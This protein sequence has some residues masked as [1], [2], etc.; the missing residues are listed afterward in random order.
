MHGGEKVGW[1][2]SQYKCQ[3]VSRC[4]YLCFKLFI[5]SSCGFAN[6]AAVC[7]QSW[8]QLLASSHP[9]QM[10]LTHFCSHFLLYI[11]VSHTDAVHPY[12]GESSEINTIGA[13]QGER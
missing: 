2:R 12:S 8:W 13:T 4:S 10:L 5:L 11:C 9:V 3:E 6:F 1:Q 7:T